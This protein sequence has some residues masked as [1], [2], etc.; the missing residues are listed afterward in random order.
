MK[1][2]K[3]A[4]FP[5]ASKCQ[6]KLTVSRV[7][8]N[9]FF[10]TSGQRFDDKAEI[11]NRVALGTWILLKNAISFVVILEWEFHVNALNMPVT[12]PNKL[13]FVLTFEGQWLVHCWNEAS[14]SQK[15]RKTQELQ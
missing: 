9:L 15:Y 1:H 8:V 7:A 11:T 2:G 10:I 3:G 6:K 5:F 13:E 12:C 4:S 14:C